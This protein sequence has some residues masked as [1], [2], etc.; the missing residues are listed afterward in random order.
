[1]KKKFVIFENCG[2]I[3][4]TRLTQGGRSGT[5][6][7]YIEFKNLSST[8]WEIFPQLSIQINFG[9]CYEYYR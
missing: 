1:M 5:H 6:P 2:E 4:I 7:A 9:G 8:I 3:R